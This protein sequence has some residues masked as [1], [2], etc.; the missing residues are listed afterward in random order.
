MTEIT[1]DFVRSAIA[2]HKNRCDTARFVGGIPHFQVVEAGKKPEGYWF[3]DL[4]DYWIPVG[5]IL[6]GGGHA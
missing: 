4:T 1:A 3:D 5:V 6:D 2:D